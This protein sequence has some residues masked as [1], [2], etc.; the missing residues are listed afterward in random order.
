MQVFSV[1]HWVRWKGEVRGNDNHF[2]HGGRR[3]GEE[4]ERE[5]GR[6]RNG[7]SQQAYCGHLWVLFSGKCY[8]L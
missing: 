2:E 5:G 6:G 4:V 1:N 3:E 7:E 8:K